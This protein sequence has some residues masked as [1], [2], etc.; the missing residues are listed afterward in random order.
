MNTENLDRHQPNAR[1]TVSPNDVDVRRTVIVEVH[2]NIEA[3][4]S[5]D[6]GHL[7]KADLRAG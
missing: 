4:A 6:S 1:L 3:K 7:A 2:P 5:D